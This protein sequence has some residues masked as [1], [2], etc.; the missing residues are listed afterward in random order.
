MALDI[1]QR[2]NGVT[3]AVKVAPGR[4]GSGIVGLWGSSLKINIAA[5]PEK[6]KANRE[7]VNLLAKLLGKEKSAITIVRGIHNRA[8]VIHVNEMNPE[9][10]CGCLAEYLR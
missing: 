10:L 5:A 4:S 9:Q 8:K 7:L 1:K 3:F 6:G 2:D